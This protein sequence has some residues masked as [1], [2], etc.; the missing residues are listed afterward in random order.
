[1]KGRVVTSDDDSVFEDFEGSARRFDVELF[2]KHP[3]MAP[4]DITTA[5][6]LEPRFVHRVGDRRW[7]PDGRRLR[8]QP[9]TRWRHSTR[10]EVKHHRFADRVTAFVDLLKPHKAFLAEVRSTGGE[11]S[12]VVQFLG[13]GYYGDDIPLRTLENMIDLRLNL[14]IECFSVPVA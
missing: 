4:A 14:S 13:D 8:D 10:H 11:A 12:V 1:M 6:G 9:D 5:L 7:T 3:T 2:I